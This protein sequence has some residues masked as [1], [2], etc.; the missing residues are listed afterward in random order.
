MKFITL[1]SRKDS[2]FSLPQAERDRLNISSVQWIFDHKMKMGSKFRIFSSPGSE[3]LI[4][5]SEFDTLEEY[6]QSLRSPTAN[7]GFMTF[8]TYPVIEADENMLKQ[9]LEMR[10]SAK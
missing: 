1:S 4:T 8:E 2:F 9:G 5:L 7:A 10:K 6:S 3:Y